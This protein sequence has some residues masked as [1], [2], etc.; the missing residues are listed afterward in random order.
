MV[1]R[2]DRDSSGLVLFARDAEAHRLLSLQFERRQVRKRYL[3][4][5]QG[6]LAED[7]RVDSPLREFGSG[8]MGVAAPSGPAGG[9][10]ALTRYRVLERL[11]AA[12]YLEVEPVTGRRHQIRAHLAS[13]GHPVMGD[14]LYGRDRPVGGAPRLMLHAFELECRGVSGETLALRCEPPEDFLRVLEQARRIC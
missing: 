6:S 13:V 12:T 8:R 7:G 11:G 4:L 1:H 9:K 5:A 2:I 3:A 14:P 10:E